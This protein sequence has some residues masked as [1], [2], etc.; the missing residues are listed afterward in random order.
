MVCLDNEHSFHFIEVQPINENYIEDDECKVRTRTTRLA[1]FI[2]DK[3]G[4]L[5]QVE[6]IDG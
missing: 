2:C 4:L 1:T 6:L 3:C 5:K